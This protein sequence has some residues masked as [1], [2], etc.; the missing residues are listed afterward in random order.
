[1]SE[2]THLHLS[3]EDCLVLLQALN[4]AFNNYM[5]L[6]SSHP[7]LTES[8]TRT[9]HRIQSLHDLVQACLVTREELEKERTDA[10]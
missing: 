7:L 2:H 1:M 9:A 6:A 3:N 10:A 8:C 5:G 4:C